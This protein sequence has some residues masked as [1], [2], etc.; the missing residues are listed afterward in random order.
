[1]IPVIFIR[2]AAQDMERVLVADLKIVI[3]EELDVVPIG[4]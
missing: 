4:T 2:V 3:G 1:V